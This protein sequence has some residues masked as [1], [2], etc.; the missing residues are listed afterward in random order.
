M[1]GDKLRD[2]P[3]SWTWTYLENCIDILDN[4]RIPV[5]SNERETRNGEIPYYGAT[6]QVGW[7][8][9]YIFDE[10]LVLLGEDGAPFLDPIKNKSYIIRGKSWVNNHAHVLRA[11][12]GLTLNQFIS[13]YLNN[14]NYSRYVTGTTRLK[15]NQAPMR[16]IP[17]PLAPFPEQLRIVARI[18]KLFS[19]LDAGVEALHKAKAYLTCYRQTV[20]KAAVEGRLTEGWR[21]AHPEVEPAEKLLERIINLNQGISSKKNGYPKDLDLS[22][23]PSLPKTW[24]WVRLDSLASLKGG[25]T[26]D[27]K[28]KINNGR[29]VPYLRVANVQRGF[30]DLSEIKE[31]EASEEV[32]SDLRLR[33]GDILFN[34]GGDRDK[35][36]RGWIWQEELHECIHQNHV[37]RARLYSNEISNKFVSWFGNT[38]GQTYFLREGKQTTNLAS[39][40]LT[41]LSAFP[42]PLPPIEEQKIVVM[43]IENCLS[44]ADETNTILDQNI[45]RADR[46]RQSI[47]K[48][49]FEGKLVLQDP[50]DEP[51]KVLLERI[52]ANKKKQTPVKKT[53]YSNK[54]VRANEK[55]REIT[56]YELLL[57]SKRSLTPSELWILSN[58]DI[59]AF[60]CRLKLE[61]E[62]GRII[63]D[64]INNKLIV[65]DERYEDR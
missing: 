9:N 30:L 50:S 33:Q 17:V 65:K 35:L 47:L 5:N 1:T 13:Y 62:M 3:E 57:S 4:Q 10:E 28:R 23:L 27:A 56:L 15:L 49:A 11:I 2:L 22:G 64:K 20:L 63:E 36:G 42:V 14:F 18:E 6:G 26:K 12:N 7:I 58:L 54:K 39:I 60:Y 46:L 19:R 45:K 48:L 61:I 44:I 24:L 40:N 59:E 43:K 55:R 38:F 25:I 8:N 52:A 31:I 37:F 21:K 53:K 29:R 32:I 41:K 34:E 51:A 16:K